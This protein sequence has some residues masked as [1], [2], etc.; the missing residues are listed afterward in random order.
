MRERHPPYLLSITTRNVQLLDLIYIIEEQITSHAQQEEENERYVPNF[1]IGDQINESLDSSDE[2]TKSKNTNDVLRAAIASSA[3]AFPFAGLPASLVT[4]AL[5][6]APRLINFSTKDSKDNDNSRSD[7]TSLENAR[8]LANFTKQH[9]I[10]RKKAKEEGYKFQPG[11]PVV[12]KDYRR[13]P[14]SE[15]NLYI[16]NDHYDAILLEERESELIKLLVHLGATKIIITRKK[17]DNR[18]KELNASLSVNSKIAGMEAGAA[19]NS[20]TEKEMLDTREFLLS[21]RHWS[22]NTKINTEKFFWLPYEPSWKAVVYAREEGECLTASLEL[23]ENTSFSSDKNLELSLRAKLLE[24]GA[25]VGIS[26]TFTEDKT[27]YIKAEFS[28]IQKIE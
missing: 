11:H 24:A 4:L 7:S 23:R 2:Q 20:N 16:P 19:L 18:H 10:T 28:E 14:L 15:D 21:G 9:S 27:Y 5:L 12:G 22:S 8:L 26:E 6:S 1:V 3:L 13:H 17:S 25:Q